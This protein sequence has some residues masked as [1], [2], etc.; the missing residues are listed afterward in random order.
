MRSHIDLRE[1]QGPL[2]RGRGPR[3][4][5]GPRGSR[6]APTTQATWGVHAHLLGLEY[7]YTAVVGVNDLALPNPSAATPQKLDQPEH[8]AALAAEA[9]CCSP[10]DEPLSPGCGHGLLT[11]CPVI[12]TLPTRE[13]V[14]GPPKRSRITGR[15]M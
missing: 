3:K 4:P 12:D 6:P 11:R 10:P 1:R 8:E 2:D 14:L 9:A 5:G 15:V 7:R 13:G